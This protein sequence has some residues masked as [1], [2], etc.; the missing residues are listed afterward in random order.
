M[1]V[2]SHQMPERVRLLLLLL[3]LLRC[4]HICELQVLGRA[5]LRKHEA[6]AELYAGFSTRHPLVQWSSLDGGD[7]TC[8]IVRWSGYSPGGAW[9]LQIQGL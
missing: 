8:L 9:P 6:C 7:G 2:W 5:V 3:L 1:Q 4:T